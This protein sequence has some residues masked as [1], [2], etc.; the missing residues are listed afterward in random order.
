MDS[1]NGS[2]PT[3]K[4]FIRFSINGYCPS[5]PYENFFEGILSKFDESTF[6]T[7][8]LQFALVSLM[9]L[10]AGKGKYWKILFYA[11][12]AGLMGA[13]IEKGTIAYTCTIHD[14]NNERYY[15]YGFLIS[16]IFWI[17]KEYSI[18]LLN[19]TKIK[20]F[21]YENS[22]KLFSISIYFLFIFFVCSRFYI[23]F[24][25]C[26]AG[27]LYNKE[28]K[29]GHMVAFSIMAF[30][31]LICTIGII[32]FVGNHNKQEYNHAK[33]ID[34]YIKRS[35]YVILI[36]V[37]IVSIF[38]VVINY[39]IAHFEEIPE[40]ADKP[41]LNIKCSFILILACDALLFKY[42]VHLNSNREY[43][44]Y[45]YEDFNLGSINING[46]AANYNGYDRNINENQRNSILNVPPF[47]YPSLNYK[48]KTNSLL[49]DIIFHKDI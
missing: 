31:D 10:N 48:K 24:K 46:I 30:A 4:G 6:Y 21:S 34:H 22:S 39:F 37:D 3:G 42:S 11:S 20:A 33:Y 19:L 40:N 8:I 18:P 29:Y 1:N 23:G 5:Q 43:S 14:M 26:T 27:V 44:N 36:F 45:N 28:I 25:R 41:F 15:I 47:I 9:Y 13:L 49:T 16:E 35:S 2:K 32:Y 12:F 38:F 17:V 7:N